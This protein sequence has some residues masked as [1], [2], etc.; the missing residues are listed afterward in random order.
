MVK[1]VNQLERNGCE[2]EVGERPYN[3]TDT[4]EL[5]CNNN[6]IKGSKFQDDTVEPRLRDDRTHD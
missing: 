3:L 2:W 4:R 6:M 1:E 5:G